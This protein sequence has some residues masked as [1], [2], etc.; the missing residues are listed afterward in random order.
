MS[1]RAKN[2]LLGVLLI[3]AT[4]GIVSALYLK[5]ELDLYL[6]DLP[7]KLTQKFG[8]P[9]S[10]EDIHTS[11]SWGVLKVAVTGVE[12]EDQQTKVPL[13]AADN[14]VGHLDMLGSLYNMQPKFSSFSVVRPRL[15][16]DWDGDGVPTILGLSG[17]HVPGV[18]DP[19]ILLQLL[20]IQQKISITEGDFHLQGRQGADL[21]F[22]HVQLEF[23]QKRNMR[24]SLVARGA[25][26]AAT[27][28]EFSVA[29]NYQGDLSD[30]RDALIDFDLRTSFVKIKDFIK[31]VPQIESSI[32][33]GSFT[34]FDLNGVMQNGK[35]RYINTEFQVEKLKLADLE[36]VR[37]KGKLSYSPT[38]EVLALDLHDLYLGIDS[39]YSHSVHIDKA[40]GSINKNAI[41]DDW[42]L[43][44]KDLQ[45]LADGMQLNPQ[46]NVNLIEQKLTTLTFTCAPQSASVP[47]VVKYLPDKIFSKTLYKWLSDSLRAGRVTNI[48]AKYNQQDLGLDIDFV[49]ATLRYSESWP[50]IDDMH[51]HLSIKDKK[52]LIDASAAKVLGHPLNNVQTEFFIT[53]KPYGPVK[54]TG[55]VDASLQDG[56]AYLQKTPLKVKLADKL[57]KYDPQGKMHVDLALDVFPGGQEETKVKVAGDLIVTN[58]TL[59]L[60]DVDIPLEKIV[61]KMQFSNDWVHAEKLDLNI[62]GHKATA[63]VKL[64]DDSSDQLQVDFNSPIDVKDIK[65]LFPGLHDLRI[66]GMTQMLGKIQIPWHATDSHQVLYLNS[67]MEGIAIDYPEPFAKQ[68]TEILPLAVEYHIDANPINMVNIDIP[69]LLS[70]SLFVRDGEFY[71]AQVILGSGKALRKAIDSL[72]IGGN[73]KDFA[74]QKWKDILQRE[75]RQNLVPVELDLQIGNLLL[76]DT[77]FKN[78]KVVYDSIYGRWKFAN[79]IVAGNITLSDTSDKIDVNLQHLHLDL[80]DG[81]NN[82][83][84]QYVHSKYAED[85]L[86]FVHLVCENFTFKGN[87]YRNVALQLMPRTYGYEI[88]EF[89]IANDYSLLQA[90]GQ[91][92]MNPEDNFTQLSGNVYTRNFGSILRDWKFGN[93]ITRGAGEVNFSLQWPGDPTAFNYLQLDG[94]SH[95]DLRSGALTDIK[96][97]LGRVIGLLNIDSIQ[98]RLQLD[99]SDITESGLSFDKLVADIKFTPGNVD[100]NNLMLNGPS[101]RIELDGNLDL[102][103]QQLDLTIFVSPKTGVG[104]PVAAA[105]AVNP[106]VGAALW[107][108][109]KAA[110]SKI[111]EITKHKYSV[112]GTLDKPQIEEVIT[113]SRGQQASAGP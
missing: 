35:M 107:L 70:T 91:W 78:T 17:E 96:P 5:K 50:S 39:L 86:P 104:I 82:N 18:I 7:G 61:G 19:E 30:Y 44:T 10:I 73:L 22:M 43:E 42:T 110:G 112:T 76:G 109:D 29:I 87:K 113:Q 95:I 68:D 71:G 16:L 1:I 103:S 48:V 25:I 80:E 60:P 32:A 45:I 108:V 28:P 69:K 66:S 20:A 63:S 93:S 81:S 56:L 62:M 21:P 88:G 11:W 53:P 92:Q 58:G 84:L 94:A 59:D 2:L 38:K 101:A 52:L 100:T 55:D 26:A 72:V 54:I 37:G 83:W 64:A 40:H 79:E 77:V 12:I 90:Q 23:R 106:A 105:I 99:F 89:A 27:P 24:Y 98:R 46:I 33:Q 65:R 9:I 41:G 85:K 13:F 102:N 15:V 75:D 49:D 74:W 57:A 34:D 14:I 6:Q 36:V 67:D 97:G 111:S 4:A 47:T 8:Y 51:A 3:S 31:F